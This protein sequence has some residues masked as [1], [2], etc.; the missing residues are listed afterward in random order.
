MTDGLQI[1]AAFATSLG[2]TWGLVPSAIR[3]A[4]RT[5]FFDRPGGYKEHSRSTTYLGGLAV[6]TGFLAASL[7]FSGA[8]ESILAILACVLVLLVVGTIDDRIGLGIVPRIVVEI[9]VAL[10]VWHFGTGWNLFELEFLNLLFTVAWVVGLINAFNL[11]DNLD[12]ATSTVADASA[13]GAGG[14]ALVEGNSVLAV[15]GFA[16]AGACC[17]FLPHNLAR[18]AKIFLGDG[19][20]MPIGFTIAAVTM[21]VDYDSN[22]VVPFLLGSL[23]VAVPALDMGAVIVSRRRRGVGVFVGGRDHMTHR[24]FR[25]LNSERS[26]SLVLFASQGSLSVL[27]IALSQSASSALVIAISILALS[28]T[29]CALATLEPLV[30]GFPRSS[31]SDP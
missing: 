11:M 1:S 31:R 15:V 18:P 19:G 26:V 3:L 20:S 30:A 12:G 21:A 9:G 23:L 13:L 4:S 6:I 28:L 22:G 24:L 8:D 7:I 25:H 10:A 29:T 2:L 17:G 5:D 14:L 27:A 16:M